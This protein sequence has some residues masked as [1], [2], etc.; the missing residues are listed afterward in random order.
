[1]LD[2]GWPEFALILIVA[3]LV[4]GPRDLPKALYTVGKWL[5]AARRV[6]TDFQRHVDDMIRE[7]E[8]EDIKKGVQTA[9]DFNVR[10]QIENAVDPTGELKGSFD[11]KAHIKGAGG[12]AAQKPEASAE[13][14]R[15]AKIAKA[16][17]APAPPDGAEPVAAAG[18]TTTAKAA[19]VGRAAKSSA[20]GG[21]AKRDTPKADG[22]GGAAGAAGRAK[23]TTRSTRKK[24]NGE[25]EAPA[26]RRQGAARGG[27]PKAPADKPPAAGGAG[28]PKSP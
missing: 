28:D 8:L 15:A 19:P 6:A 23:T 4:I 2:I 27:R 13:G 20:G 9:R 24:S 12:D 22:A 11:V 21:R 10:K 3:L 14:G 7:A 5:R 25:A 16:A 17:E 26:G 18:S 1:M